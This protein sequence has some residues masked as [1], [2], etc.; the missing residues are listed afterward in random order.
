MLNVTGA[1]REVQRGD[2][3]NRTRTAHGPSPC[4]SSS[5]R[6]CTCRQSFF[7]DESVTYADIREGR[8][9]LRRAV[10]HHIVPHHTGQRT[11]STPFDIVMEGE[12]PG[13]N[14]EQ[15]AAIVRPY[16]DAGATWWMESRWSAASSDVVR[17]RI[18]QGPPRVE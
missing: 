1:S 3:V 11:Q 9:P 16:A 7:Q 17:T 8:E 13:D 14:P 12:T 10:G 18:R 2:N 15:A 5:P 4:S 6:Y